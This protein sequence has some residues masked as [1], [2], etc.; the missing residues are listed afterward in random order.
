MWHKLI[1][2]SYLNYVMFVSYC[3]NP[4]DVGFGHQLSWTLGSSPPSVLTSNAAIPNSWHVLL[5]THSLCVAIWGTAG[6][7]NPP[8]QPNCP[9]GMHTSFN[10]LV[11]VQLPQL[12]KV[13]ELWIWLLVYCLARLPRSGTTGA[14]LGMRCIAPLEM[15]MECN[16]HVENFDTFLRSRLKWLGGVSWHWLLGFLLVTQFRISLI[17]R[18]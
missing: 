14:Y 10:E 11:L 1:T 18:A 16:I 2:C 13:W 5:P 9:P 15:L 4:T 7:P 3:N 17:P 12:C 8:T 6:W